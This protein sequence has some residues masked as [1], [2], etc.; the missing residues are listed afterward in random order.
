MIVDI[1]RNRVSQKWSLSELLGRFLWA[2]VWPFFRLSPRLCWGWRRFLLRVFGARVE[3][4]VHVF[5]TVRIAVPWNVSLGDSC[6]VGDRAIL[7]ALGPIR[8]GARATVSQGAHLCAGTHDIHDP[9]RPLLKLP[10]S[11]G[12]D[13]WVCADAFIGPG[14]VVG[15]GAIVGARA[16]AV[17]EVPAKSIVAGNPAR[18][19]GSTDS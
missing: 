12:N 17:K 5:P 6:A 2:L 9:A 7:Y 13:A 8:I 16:V 14:V 19:I 18:Q 11:I 10:I 1:E 15:E 3:R 4:Q